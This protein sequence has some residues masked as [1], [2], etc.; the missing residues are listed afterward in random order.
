MASELERLFAIQI[1]TSRV[2][3]H[4]ESEYRF[5]PPRQWRF[6]FAWP[7][8][9]LAVEIQGGTWSRGRHSRGKGQEADCEK[10]SRA[11]VLGWRVLLVTGDQVRDGRAIGWLSECFGWRGNEG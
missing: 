10:L 4:G 1:A 11:A 3:P 9:K 6:D 2:I 5:S 8:E 7:S